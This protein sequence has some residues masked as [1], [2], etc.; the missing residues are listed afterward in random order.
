MKNG[1][2]DF[3]RKWILKEI[4]TK[5]WKCEKR[6]IRVYGIHNFRRNVDNC[7][8]FWVGNLIIL[9][10]IVLGPLVLW[11]PFSSFFF[12]QIFSRDAFFG[13]NIRF[14][15]PL[16]HNSLGGIPFVVILFS[17]RKKQFSS[18][19]PSLLQNVQCFFSSFHWIC[20]P[21]SMAATKKMKAFQWTLFRVMIMWLSKSSLFFKFLSSFSALCICVF[22]WKKILNMDNTRIY[23]LHK[24]HIH[25]GCIKCI[26][27]I[28]NDNK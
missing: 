1:K 14:F 25:S 20:L 2:T 13:C 26:S 7:D 28:Y 12:H 6:N 17:I 5:E 15:L 3:Q 9:L 11:K 27:N 22:I 23:I 4:I 18:Y 10:K 24:N 19:L 16:I 21:L 8:Q